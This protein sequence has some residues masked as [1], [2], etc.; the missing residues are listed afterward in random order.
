[1]AEEADAEALAVRLVMLMG[2]PPE[3]WL[4]LVRLCVLLLAEF[5]AGT[6][7]KGGNDGH[8]L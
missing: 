4:R 6:K 7:E 3:D 8:S 2:C 1:M 5:S